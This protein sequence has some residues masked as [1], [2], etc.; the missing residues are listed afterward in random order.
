MQGAGKT[1]NFEEDGVVLCGSVCNT[2]QMFDKHPA[3]EG[4]V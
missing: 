3:V 4:K 1:S 2:Q